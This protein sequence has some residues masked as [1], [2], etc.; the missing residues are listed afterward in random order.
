M[1]FVGTSC[2]SQSVSTVQGNHYPQSQPWN[3]C[4]LHEQSRLFLPAS[5][6][7]AL[8]I[9]GETTNPVVTLHVGEWAGECGYT[10]IATGKHKE[11]VQWLYS[12]VPNGPCTVCA[13]C[14]HAATTA[15][16]LC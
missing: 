10:A 13:M 5:S 15:S 4:L 16:A 1:A 7:N 3:F 2:F 14:N 9:Q 6:W 8:G 12:H 11:Y